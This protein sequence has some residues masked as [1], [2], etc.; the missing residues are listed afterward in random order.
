MQDLIKSIHLTD[1]K[2][3]A[4]IERF[5]I[6]KQLEKDSVLMDVGDSILF[7]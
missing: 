3:L 7:E 1:S 5:A 6:E 4:E 2:L